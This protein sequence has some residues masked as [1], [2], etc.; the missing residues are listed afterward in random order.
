MTSYCSSTGLQLGRHERFATK[1]FPLPISIVLYLV[2]TIAVLEADCSTPC[3]PDFWFD[4]FWEK[5]EGKTLLS[6]NLVIEWA[7]IV[8][9]GGNAIPT[10]VERPPLR[11]QQQQRTSRYLT[12]GAPNATTFSSSSYYFPPAS[13]P[14]II[15]GTTSPALNSHVVMV[16]LPPTN[17]STLSVPHQPYPLQAMSIPVLSSC[18]HTGADFSDSRAATAAGTSAALAKSLEIDPQV[19]FDPEASFG[20][21]GVSGGGGD[22]GGNSKESHSHSCRPSRQGF[23]F[24]DYHYHYQQHQQ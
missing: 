24:H 15:L 13:T 17:T 12:T 10:R 5:L 1:T 8:D 23:G 16:S 2:Y 7:R 20:D 21:A 19:C 18:G 6:H 4:H 22:G 14:E 9:C 3:E 11:Q